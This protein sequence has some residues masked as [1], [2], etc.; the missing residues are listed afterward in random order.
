MTWNSPRRTPHPDGPPV[1]GRRRRR[2]I[3]LAAGSAAVL[4]LLSACGGGG[5]AADPGDRP[6]R[7]VLAQTPFSM[8]PCDSNHSANGPLLLGNITESL[9]DIDITTGE[10]GP[11]LA[12]EWTQTS[13]TT[14]RFTLRPGVTFH[15]GSALTGE[16]VAAWI[17]RIN[18][19]A[20]NC[21]LRG[22]IIDDNLQTA[23]AVDATTVD[24]QLAEPDPILPRRLAFVSIG[25]V[26][27][28]P[29]TKA[30]TPIGTGPYAF[31]SY[32]PGSDLEVQRFDG[33]W[34][35]APPY[36]SVVYSFREESSVRAA[37]A[38]TGEA[39]IAMAIGPQDANMP[40]AVT[41][42]VAETVYYRLDVTLAPLNDVRVRTA[43]G[44]AIDR[45]TL[46]DNVLGGKGTP[47]N[48]IFLPSVVGY[49]QDVTWDYDPELARRLIAEARA[50]GVAVDTPFTVFAEANTRG[51]NG[52]EL[53]D[54]IAAMLQ[55]V[56]LTVST[57]IVPD[58]RERLANP[59]NPAYS[60]ALVQNVHGNSLGDAYI[61]L[62]GKLGC[63]ATQ[64]PVCDERFEQ[65]LKAGGEA[66]GEQRGVLLADAA[67][68]AATDLVAILPIAHLTDTMVITNERIHYTP[69]SAT[70][71]RLVIAEMTVDPAGA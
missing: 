21:Y 49:P 42:T 16:S 37:M 71:E 60:P 24:I 18:D 69:N 64:S 38:S 34:G 62:Y 48:E 17:N 50:A 20:A 41:Y 26:P 65:L 14:W 56:G 32:S 57:E 46:I 1:P 5:G 30:A 55:A 11:G 43:I 36:P 66:S 45:K 25:V 67:R 19:P 54:T 53:P 47:A 52:T 10:L 2:R 7:V 61:S 63:G 29:A 6:L 44:H 27:P 28:D 31:V 58:D 12:T 70:S 39:D 33:Y 51:T 59:I 40:G 68:F 13:P 35:D 8:D 9:V 3:A 4:A 22:A 23:T 15:D